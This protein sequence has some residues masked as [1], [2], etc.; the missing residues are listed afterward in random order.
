MKQKKKATTT[1][2]FCCACSK[3]HPASKMTTIAR[4]H[5]QHIEERFG[6]KIEYG[7]ESLTICKSKHSKFFSH[8]DN[9]D[10]SD[11]SH[12]SNDCD[13]CDYTVR[14]KEKL[15]Q[16]SAIKQSGVTPINHKS[17]CGFLN[18]HK[19][20]VNGEQ[21]YDRTGKSVVGIVKGDTVFSAECMKEISQ[22]N[23][24]RCDHCKNLQKR[25]RQWQSR[26][27]INDNLDHDKYKQYP[28]IIK[29]KLELC[30]SQMKHLPRD[31]AD[32]F[33]NIL[34]LIEGFEKKNS[35]VPFNIF[36][37]KDEIFRTLHPNTTQ[38]I[39][40]SISTFGL[41]VNI[42]LLKNYSKY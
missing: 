10:I 39:P 42:I 3:S 7:E 13:N 25:V 17:C 36:R 29:K 34:N 18:E 2:M 37:L 33:T 40:D 26:F 28:E 23:R 19:D 35:K 21:I 8:R 24:D 11:N 9:R 20:W 41:F 1:R 16:Q 14:K 31:E 27:D 12:H 6:V 5:Q 38:K 32:L 22:K 30:Q 4:K 15:V